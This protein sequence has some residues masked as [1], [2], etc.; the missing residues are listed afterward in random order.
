MRQLLLASAFALAALPASAAVNVTID[1]FSLAQ[2][3]AAALV[4]GGG[5]VSSGPLAC[6]QGA[7]SFV[8]EFSLELLASLPPIQSQAAVAGGVFDILNGTG[9][10]GDVVLTYTLPVSL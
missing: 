8:R 4:V 10:T 7:H 9:E 2:G 6:V 3:P 5:P 1:P